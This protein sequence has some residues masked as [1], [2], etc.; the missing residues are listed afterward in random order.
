MKKINKYIALGLGALT[1]ASCESL[2]TEYL[3]YYV[4]SDQKANTLEQNPSMA[5][6]AVTGCFSVFSSYGSVYSSHFDFGYPAIMLGLDLQG[7]DM[8]TVNSGY[9]WFSYWEAFSSPTASGTPTIMAWFHLYDQ[10]YACNNVA[11]TI[12]PD[13][14]DATLKFY[15]SQAVACRAFDYWVLAQLYQHNYVGNEN[16]PCVPIITDENSADA[17]ANGCARAT[18]QEVYDQVLA[19]LNEAI[20]LLSSTNVTPASVIDSKPNRMI[21][22]A[23]AYGLRARAYLT[24][25]KYAEAAAD[26]Q[27]AIDNFSD[28]PYSI[29]EAS[30]PGFTSLNDHSWMWGIAINENDRVV[31]TGICNWPSMAVTFCG[32][33]YVTV[34][35]WKWAASDLYAAINPADVRKGWFLDENL[36]SSNLSD[37][38]QAYIDT[39]CGDLEAYTNVKFAAYE[40]ELG[41]STNAND[42]P[43]MRIEEMYYILAEGQAMSGDPALGKETI[44][45]FIQTYRCPTWTTSASTAEEVQEAIYQDRRVEFWGE[46]LS[47]FDLQR[48]G[49]VIDR[50]HKNFPAAYSYVLKANDPVRVYCIPIDEINGNPLI[51]ESDNNPEASRPQPVI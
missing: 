39:E 15:R 27:S 41:T 6:A 4:T 35:A 3:G 32:N 8:A 38:E 49:K 29:E 51:N 40:N 33:G 45:K 50:S 14:E 9:N 13:T 46:G 10:I 18:V 31:T 26:A 48:L 5:Q 25:H 34:G 21:T 1:L 47:W 37:Q 11:A 28:S 22:L 20:A 44:T 12:S 24:M 23:T 42:I 36:K 43:L 2:D 30:H 7:A 16:Q 17:A 19:D